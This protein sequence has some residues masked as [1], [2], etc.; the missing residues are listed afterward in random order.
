MERHKGALN[1]VDG[2]GGAEGNFSADKL[3]DSPSEAER[4]ANSGEFGDT[5]ERRY[6]TPTPKSGARYYIEPQEF[7]IFLHNFTNDNRTLGATLLLPGKPSS[8]FGVVAGNAGA[9][10]VVKTTSKSLSQPLCS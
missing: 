10:Y 2:L 1:W 4:H 3:G 5:L 9:P 7:A 8:T 6:K